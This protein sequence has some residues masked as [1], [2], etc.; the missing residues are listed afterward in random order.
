MSLLQRDLVLAFVP[1]IRFAAQARSREREGAR[2]ALALWEG[3][4]PWWV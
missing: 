4:G 1:L 3:E 2:S